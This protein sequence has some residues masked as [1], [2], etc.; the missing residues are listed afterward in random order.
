MTII[1][2]CARVLAVKWTDQKCILSAREYN[3]VCRAHHRIIRAHKTR[4]YF[5]CRGRY[6]YY[7]KSTTE[8]V[9]R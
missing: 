3:I 4:G 9:R 6:Y 8:N 2:C 5:R 7:K 1:A